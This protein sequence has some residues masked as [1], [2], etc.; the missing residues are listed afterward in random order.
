MKTTVPYF[1]G[2]DKG[3]WQMRGKQ[4]ATVLDARYNAKPHLEDLQRADVVVLVKR[5]AFVFGELAL[6]SGRPLIWDVLDY[7]KQPEQNSLGGDDHTVTVRQWK[8]QLGVRALIGATE[9]MA[10]MIG[11]VYIPHHCRIGLTP[12]PP[13]ARALVV[14]YD[15]S[16]RYLGA[17]RTTIEDACARQGMKF[18]V[19]PSDLTTADVLVAF[20][21]DPWD[22]WAC[23]HWKSGVKY[24]NA[25]AA[26]RPILT[27]WST[28]FDEI[29][30]VGA[31]VEKPSDFCEAL[32][33]VS[34]R[35]I[36]QQAYEDGLR[37]GPTFTVEAIA[38]QY[39]RLLHKVASRRAA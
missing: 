35:D 28:A 22:G 33:A 4:I 38:G 10:S 23:R 2:C 26:G 16:P 6:E 25:I 24:V 27:Q 31:Q 32:M 3:A 36:R 17:W 21:D 11:G 19:N 20:R 13:R 8:T 18:V 30:P 15:G 12:K 37:R 9:Q 14:G 29:W 39:R 34:H 7:W 1:I 5:A